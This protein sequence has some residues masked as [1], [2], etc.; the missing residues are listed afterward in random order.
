MYGRLSAP[1]LSGV[2][3]LWSKYADT[4]SY[5]ASLARVL[6]GSDCLHNC[7]VMAST[8]GMRGGVYKPS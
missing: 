8:L 3:W 1:Q 6:C 7:A 4:G 5:S 2:T